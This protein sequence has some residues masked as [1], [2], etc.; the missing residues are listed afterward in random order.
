MTGAVGNVSRGVAMERIDSATLIETCRA[1]V[2]VLA[3]R[4][5]DLRAALEAWAITVPCREW[6]RTGDG[7][8]SRRSGDAWELIGDHAG[9]ARRF[10]REHPAEPPPALVTVEGVDP[11]WILME[12]ARATP[13]GPDGFQ[14][15]LVVVQAD[16]PEFLD[17]L[18]QADLRGVLGEERTEVFAG[19]DASTRLA[20]WLG[21]RFETLLSGPCI[22]L[23]SVRTRATPRVQEVLERAR[24]EQLEE[25][26]RLL[27]EARA[28]YAGRTKEWWGQRFAASLACQ[29]VS[30]HSSPV[31]SSLRPLGPCGE[32][33]SLGPLRALVPTSRFTTFMQHS[34][35]DLMEALQAAGC[36]SDLLVEP[37]PF[38]RLSSLAYLRR[39]VARRPDLVVMINWTRAT[40]SMPLPREL[41]VVSWM[42]DAM[43]R[44]FDPAAASRGELDFLVGNLHPE[45]FRL[46]G[47][48]REWTL[49]FPVVAS[50]RKFHDGP[51][52]EELRRRL[53]CE[54]GYVGHQSETA[55]AMHE[56]LTREA[57]RRGERALARAMEALR[58]R[59][60]QVARGATGL[61][62]A[63]LEEA[64]AAAL[65]E[66]TGHH[67]DG[68]EVAR[69]VRQ[70]AAP[71]AER[72]IRH[73]TLE[74]AA[75]IALRRRWRM[76][77]FGRGWDRH[78]TLAAFACGE[79]AHG[80][81]LR[82]AYQCAAVQLHASAAAMVH[83]R[84]MEC[85]LSGGLPACRVARWEEPSVPEYDA[86]RLLTGADVTFTDGTG[87]ERI[88][89]R[90]IE[91]PGW[92]AACSASIA[93]R[94]R[95]GLTHDVFVARVLELVRGA[96]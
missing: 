49:E 74:W 88:V 7:N 36:E 14:P 56:R 69:L 5:V 50:A 9:A 6:Y 10:A 93:A 63:R 72:L 13:R 47:F 79:L 76:R 43:P 8:V 23:R 22:P 18:A 77:I 66:L 19:P 82:A 78:P 52:A 64:C 65:K 48:G 92:R 95:V 80:E 25:H 15:R 26:H 70:Y 90:A 38:S 96:L 57:M 94:V 21:E 3:R 24:A 42:Q 17:G 27:A 30:P 87:L 32:T 41:P 67:A 33:V 84:V 91:E 20:A 81:E 61:L 44:Q 60:E 4:G 28:I 34:A 46:F 54:I 83:Q 53:E 59:V 55:P 75:S 85:A 73:Q 62:L 40:L 58:P 89:E 2:E 1:N 39:I 71:L 86:E 29:P 51:V 35:A 68:R 12:V 45:L 11:P 31:S 37:D 16:V